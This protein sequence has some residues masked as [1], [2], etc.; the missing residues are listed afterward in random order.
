LIEAE[1]GTALRVSYDLRLVG[2]LDGA[3]WS[4]DGCEATVLGWLPADL[5]A[6]QLANAGAAAAAKNITVNNKRVILRS[7]AA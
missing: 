3:A 6:S 7:L 2:T 1:A 4:L 5:C